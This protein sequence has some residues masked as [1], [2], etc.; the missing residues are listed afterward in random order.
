[1]AAQCFY[2]HSVAPVKITSV[3]VL[4]ITCR[5]IGRAKHVSSCCF[6]GLF[7]NFIYFAASWIQSGN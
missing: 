4:N 1:M 6:G 7:C 5:Y 2:Y 3:L